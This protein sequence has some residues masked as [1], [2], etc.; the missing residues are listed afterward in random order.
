MVL[1]SS[2]AWLNSSRRTCRLGLELLS[3]PAAEPPPPLDPPLLL[4]RRKRLVILQDPC[5]L[6]RPT[7][8]RRKRWR[9]LQPDASHKMSLS[10]SRVCFFWFLELFKFT[11]SSYRKQP[12]PLDWEKS[13]LSLLL[14]I[15]LHPTRQYGVA[16]TREVDGLVLSVLALCLT[17]RFP[18]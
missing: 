4:L 17:V 3:S 6:T 8:P 11:F 16:G 12:S 14:L 13:F 2:M 7:T 1:K 10:V 9:P 18:H 15:K 5:F